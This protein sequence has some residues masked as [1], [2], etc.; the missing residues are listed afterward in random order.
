ML[1]AAGSRFTYAGLVL[2]RLLALSANA[3]DTR[4]SISSGADATVTVMQ[5]SREK[6]TRHTAEFSYHRSEIAEL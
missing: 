3:P 5:H 4:Q 2:S 1:R 6:V